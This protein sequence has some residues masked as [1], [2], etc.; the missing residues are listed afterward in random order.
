MRSRHFLLVGER[1][2]HVALPMLEP[3]GNL[4]LTTTAADA[5]R[6]LDEHRFS[7]TGFFADI[8]L[9]DGT[10]FDVLERAWFL[11]IYV[12]GLVATAHAGP[13]PNQE[14]EAKEFPRLRRDADGAMYWE[15]AF[16]AHPFT[17]ENVRIQVERWDQCAADDHAE[18][19]LFVQR[20]ACEREV[21]PAEIRGHV[22]SIKAKSKAP[23]LAAAAR[24]VR[25][26]ATRLRIRGEDVPA[27]AKH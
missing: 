18:D 5:V 10:A 26:E 4:E 12:P 25:R 27:E 11:E 9:P 22:E 19:E 7:L 17:V 14:V 20:L 16:L 6:I 24:R 2:C 3:L 1:M 21:D 13:Y 8:D 15:A 23:S